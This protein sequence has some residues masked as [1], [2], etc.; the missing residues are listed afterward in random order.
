MKSSAT[1]LAAVAVAL[2][3]AT[4]TAAPRLKPIMQDWKVK[5]TSAELMLTGAAPY[6]EEGLRRILAVLVGDLQGI[7]AGIQQQERSSARHQAP[8]FPVRGRRR[9]DRAIARRQRPGEEPFPAH[10]RRLPS[11]PRRLRQL[12]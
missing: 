9:R 10:A 5:A 4:A 11:L 7:E 1:L 2:A 8:L 12:T 6:D 3:T